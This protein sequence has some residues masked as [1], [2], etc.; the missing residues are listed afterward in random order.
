MSNYKNF[1]AKLVFL[2]GRDTK[3][4]RGNTI[5]LIEEGNFFVNDLFVHLRNFTILNPMLQYPLP[6]FFWVFLFWVLEK[7]FDDILF[8]DFDDSFHNLTYKDSMF[9][10]WARYGCENVDYVF[11]GDDDTLLRNQNLREIL[12]SRSYVRRNIHQYNDE[13]RKFILGVES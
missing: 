11:K 10:T 5:K 3:L 7:S 13:N 4:G 9:F 12:K 2:L 1:G 8:G 6:P